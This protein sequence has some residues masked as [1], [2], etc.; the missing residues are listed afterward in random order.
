MSKEKRSRVFTVL[1]FIASIIFIIGLVKISYDTFWPEKFSQ[2]EEKYYKEIASKAW[3]EGLKSISEQIDTNNELISDYSQNTEI[4]T[5]SFNAINIEKIIVESN[6][7][8]RLTFDFSNTE[9]DTEYKSNSYFASIFG[10]ILIPIVV[11][12]TLV[13]VLGICSETIKDFIRVRKMKKS[14]K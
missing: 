2:E 5:I 3:N 14:R 13:F 11:Y 7:K 10:I 12:A 6:K 1:I 4:I 9:I 8:G